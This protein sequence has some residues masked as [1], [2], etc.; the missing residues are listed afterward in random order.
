MKWAEPELNG[1]VYI[2]QNLRPEDRR[3]VYLSDRVG[4]REAVLRSWCESQICRMIVMDDGEPAGLTG[5]NGDRIWM[6]GT[7]R[8]T[9]T[10]KGCLQL[11]R[12]GRVW[13]EHCLQEVGRPLWNDVYSKNTQSIAWLR[14]LGFTVEQARP[15]GDS[16]ALFRR[17]WR[18]A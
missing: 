7:P 1:V 17:F 12:E 9:S 10:R 14:S 15:L 11:C 4:P 13:V 2:A 6:L 5:V 18:A 8:L 16:G 3:E